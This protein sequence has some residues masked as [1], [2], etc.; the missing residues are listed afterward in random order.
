MELHRDDLLAK[1]VI[2]LLS[3]KFDLGQFRHQAK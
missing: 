1:A 2:P 3:K